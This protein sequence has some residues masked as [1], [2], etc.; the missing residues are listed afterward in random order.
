MET[1][2]HHLKKKTCRSVSH[3]RV[4]F[5]LASNTVKTSQS[6]ACQ[7]NLPLQFLLFCY[8][9]CNVERISEI[10]LSTLGPSS[11]NQTMRTRTHISKK[12]HI[13]RLCIHVSQCFKLSPRGSHYH[14]IH[15]SLLSWR[16]S[17][18]VLPFWYAAMKAALDVAARCE[19]QYLHKSSTSAIVISS[20]V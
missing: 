6:N 5:L 19:H 14:K 17:F 20:S 15:V 10:L 7:W 2:S 16:N 11:E 9:Y 8:K 18:H 13:T 3:T 4:S 12:M 1:S